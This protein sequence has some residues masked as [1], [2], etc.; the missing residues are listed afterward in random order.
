MTTQ[1]WYGRQPAGYEADAIASLRGELDAAAVDAHLFANFEVGGHEIDLLVVKRDGMY[2]VELKK[3]GGPVVGAVNGEWQVRNGT[4]DSLLPGGRNENPYQQ[5]RT[6]YR[7]L[8]ERLEC[9]K[10]EF[11]SPYKANLTRFRSLNYRERKEPKVEIRSL[12]TFYPDLPAGSQ[13]DLAWPIKAVSFGEL[14]TR[15]RQTT[16]GV[17]LTNDEIVKLAQ[18]L[19]LTPWVERSGTPPSSHPKV[20]PAPL[21]LPPRGISIQNAWQHVL[22]FV[23]TFLADRLTASQERLLAQ[24]QPDTPSIQ[25]EIRS[26][27]RLPRSRLELTTP[28]QPQPVLINE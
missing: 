5:M 18:A 13:L 10:S 1:L 17:N 3:V 28:L 7:L 16:K 6:Q 14:P 22:L 11:F 26:T 25:K 27:P 12:L 23:V 19:H 15:L 4:V 9:L 24:L 8:T 20:Q 2:L 21:W